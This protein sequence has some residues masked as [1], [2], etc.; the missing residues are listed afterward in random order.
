MDFRIER[1]HSANIKG[2]LL[3]ID[4]NKP[5][6]D[7]KVTSFIYT[8]SE[9]ELEDFVFP[10]IWRLIPDSK[11]EYEIVCM[12]ESR[13]NNKDNSVIAFLGEPCDVKEGDRVGFIYTG[14][15]T[16]PISHYYAKN[17]ENLV[18]VN[19][20]GL[21]SVLKPKVGSAYS[22]AYLNRDFVFNIYAKEC[23][24][25]YGNLGIDFRF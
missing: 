24:V 20:T 6:F 5:L 3:Y 9:Y 4:M 25:T 21:M 17:A 10:V 16:V 14:R 7:G 12:A 15:G 1:S 19:Y 22:F 18:N 11:D 23:I 8:M 2:P 13:P